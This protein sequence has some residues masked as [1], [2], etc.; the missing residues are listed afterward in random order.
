MTI[1]WIAEID[2]LSIYQNITY[3]ELDI[4]HFVKI[5]KIPANIEKSFEKV[6]VTKLFGSRNGFCCYYEVGIGLLIKEI[7]KGYV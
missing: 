2:N 4:K 7:N 5:E 6:C 1:N 3:S